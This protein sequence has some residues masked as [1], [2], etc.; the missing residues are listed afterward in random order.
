[1]QTT[2]GSLAMYIALKMPFSKKAEESGAIIIGKT[3]LNGLIF[4]QRNRV[5]G[6]VAEV[7]RLKPYIFGS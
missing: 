7:V 3:N 6:G 2:T 5:L 1:M 4:V